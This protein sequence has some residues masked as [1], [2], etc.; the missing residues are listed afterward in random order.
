MTT[1]SDHRGRRPLGSLMTQPDAASVPSG[2]HLGDRVVV[3][4]RL[5]GAAPADWRASPNPPVPSG[6]HQ[7]AHSDVTGRLLSDGD[8]LVLDRDGA[9]ESIPRSAITSIRLLSSMPVRNSEIRGLEHAAALAWPGI[10]SE[11]L[12]GWLVRTGAGITRRA[13]SAIPLDRSARVDADAMADIASRYAAHGLPTLVSLPDRLLPRQI[14]GESASDEVHVLVRDLTAVSADPDADSVVVRLEPTPSD[15]WLAAYFGP[16]TGATDMAR[17]VVEAAQAPATYA[18][19]QSH[20][21]LLAIG[22]GAVT[23]APDAHRWLGVS[24]LW[25]DPDHRRSGLGGEV[26]ARLLA[27]GADQGAQRAYVQVEASNRV[28]GNWY[29]AQGFVLHHQNRY[30]SIPAGTGR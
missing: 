17:R 12:H 28:A 29:R 9:A 18:H 2:A 1:T 13:N 6:S 15:A 19:L 14:D 26:L 7:P 4:Y 25:T 16:T 8:P 24:S 22:R 27:W 30:L 11:W 21:Q 20:G 3:R 5:G 10:D 23:E